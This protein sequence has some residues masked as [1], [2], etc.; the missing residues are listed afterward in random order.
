MAFCIYCG[1]ALTEG[2]RF[3]AG[4]GKA[5]TV[6]APVE[7]PP[8]VAVSGEQ[9]PQYTDAAFCAVATPPRLQYEQAAQ[10]TVALEVRVPAAPHVGGSTCPH[11]GGEVHPKAVLCVHC[12]QQLGKVR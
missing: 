9:P 11:C 6:S 10:P 3:C 5:V 12:G 7:E 4:C 1:R 8:A 2:S